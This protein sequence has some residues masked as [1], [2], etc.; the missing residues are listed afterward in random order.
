MISLRQRAG[1]LK[2]LA[3]HEHLH[4]K[5][6]ARVLTRPQVLVIAGQEMIE[7]RMVGRFLEHARQTARCRC[8]R[9]DGVARIRFAGANVGVN[10]DEQALLRVAKWHG[11]P[12][13]GC[14]AARP[15]GN[16]RTCVGESVPKLAGQTGDRL[17]RNGIFLKQQ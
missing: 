2:T 17:T 4:C 5:S 16:S 3:E 11:I 12:L 7:L 9:R 14:V 6:A 8:R 10:C 13:N 1:L 15:H